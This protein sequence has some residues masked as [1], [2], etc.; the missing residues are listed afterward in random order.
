[1]RFDPETDYFGVMTKDGTPKTFFKPDPAQ[2]GYE[3]NLDYFN[4]Q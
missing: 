3:S 4:A 1:V 2:H